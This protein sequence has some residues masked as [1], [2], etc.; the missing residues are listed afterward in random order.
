MSHLFR[1]SRS[2]F[3]PEESVSDVAAA[4]VIARAVRFKAKSY[5]QRDAM[6]ISGLS[7]ARLIAPVGL[8]ASAER[9]SCNVPPKKGAFST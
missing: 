3:L 9:P 7:R 2:S 6:A 4:V 1:H 8:L 5:Y